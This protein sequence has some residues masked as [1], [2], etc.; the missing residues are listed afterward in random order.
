MSIATKFLVGIGS[1]FVLAI[2]A[3]MAIPAKAVNIDT[4]RDCDQYAVM[5]CGAM[6]K[7]EMVKKLK[8]GDGQN[9]AKNI[10]EI[11]DK[12]NLNV[13]D[14]ENAKFKDGTVFKD[15]DVKVDNKVVAKNAKT[16]IRTVSTKKVDANQMG[17]A[18]A[19]K[20]A[21]DENGKFLFAVMTPCGNPV[22]ADAVEPPKPRV[23]AIS[24]D[25]LKV[26][27]NY[28]T[29]TVN[30]KVTGSASNT[31][32]TGYTINFG[33]TTVV[34]QQSATH[35]YGGT[36]VVTLVASVTG[37]VDG[38]NQ[39]VSSAACTKSIEF[40]AGPPP[41]AAQSIT[42]SLLTLDA[43]NKEKKY[44]KV[45]VKGDAQNTKID[46]YSVNFG[47]GTIVDKQTAEHTYAKYGDYN[48]VAT[49]TGMVDGEKKTVGGVSCTQTVSF[50]ETPVA[51]PT[52]P[53]LPENDPKCKPCPTNPELN[54]DDP[55]C[56]TPVTPVTPVTPTNPTLPNTGAGS[57]I[58]LM[59]GVSILGAV[60]HRFWL[61]KKL[62]L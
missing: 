27:V 44:V 53:S 18:Q 4:T 2:V 19:A 54:F 41:P 25:A 6:N 43:V 49:V 45:S 34:N 20:V 13:K 17:S 32:I 24:C 21:F 1:I 26:D 39:T 51:C 11:Y 59:T 22:S 3:L 7:T 10:K 58:G 15:G 35:T 40:K 30:A 48:I 46:T 29:K 12:F 47:D 31:N 56:T 28:D 36:G 8:D 14:I 52:N 16:Y 55:K 23:Q 62:G 5:Y 37:P 42:C 33:D 9:S 50:K 61:S 57:V 60:G 38:A